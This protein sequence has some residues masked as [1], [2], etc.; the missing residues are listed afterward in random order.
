[1]DLHDKNIKKTG[2]EGT[3]TQITQKPYMTDPQ[4]IITEWGEAKTLLDL[5]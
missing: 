3:Y 1:M 2:Y 5:R 4:L